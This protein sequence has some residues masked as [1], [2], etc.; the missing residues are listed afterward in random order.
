MKSSSYLNNNLSVLS[1]ASSLSSHS[2]SQQPSYHK[3]SLSQI[4]NQ[5]QSSSSSS[6]SSSFNN[7]NRFYDRQSIHSSSVNNNNS[8]NNNTNIYLTSNQVKKDFEQLK[9]SIKELE[10]K[11]FIIDRNYTHF[12]DVKDLEQY[13]HSIKDNLNNL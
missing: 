7:I 5:Q 2:H 11:L 12:E 4:L 9:S 13:I 8:L 6:L 3:T 10:N 1:S